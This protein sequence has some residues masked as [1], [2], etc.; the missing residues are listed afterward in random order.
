MLISEDKLKENLEHDNIHHMCILSEGGLISE[1]NDNNKRQVV[2]KFQSAEQLVTDLFN[3]YPELIVNSSSNYSSSFKTISIFSLTNSFTKENYSFDL[4]KKHGVT[5]KTLL[6]DFNLI[7]FDNHSKDLDKDKNLSEFLYFLKSETPNILLKMNLQVQKLAN[8]DYL[9]GVKFGPDLYDLTSTDLEFWLKA[10]KK[11]E[12]EVIIFN[13]G[14]YM[15]VV[16]ELFGRSSELLLISSE[17]P[18]D[19]ELY[20]NLIDQLYWTGYEDI[21][22]KIEVVELGEDTDVRKDY[23]VGNINKG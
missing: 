5:K 15:E 7:Q 13:I 6:V 14:C 9:K 2:Y 12:Y 1:N 11:S 8:F 18:W 23:Q 4:A 22:K 20:N 17:D 19:K 21:I 10:L 3:L 16:L